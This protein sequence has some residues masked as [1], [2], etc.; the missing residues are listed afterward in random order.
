MMGYD[1]QL[2]SLLL[3]VGDDFFGKG[4]VEAALRFYKE[5]VSLFPGTPICLVKVAECHH[6]MVSVFVVFMFSMVA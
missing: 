3:R 4:N 6:R 5:A 1:S 2:I